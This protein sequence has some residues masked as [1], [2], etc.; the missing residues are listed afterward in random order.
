MR[1]KDEK[2]HGLGSGVI[3]SKDGFILTNNHVVDKATDVQVELLDGRRLKAKVI[4]TDKDTDVAV[5]KIT[6][7]DLPTARLGDSRKSRVGDLVFAIGNPFNVGQTVT[8]G[9]IS[10]KS[11]AYGRIETFQDFIQTDASINPGNSGGALINA[12]G[13][14]VGINTAILANGSEG[15]QGIGF[16]HSHQHGPERDEPARE[17]RESCPWLHGRDAAERYS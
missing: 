10:A 14:V 8:M 13:D 6:A 2:A 15:N 3:V 17:E 16:R 1:P 5:L 4:G 11:R 9:I 12:N 7:E